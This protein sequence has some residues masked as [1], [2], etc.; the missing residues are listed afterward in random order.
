MR[1][2]RRRAMVCCSMVSDL[3]RLCWTGRV[4]DAVVYREAVV[5]VC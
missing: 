1:W 2:A 5:V 3:S 4:H